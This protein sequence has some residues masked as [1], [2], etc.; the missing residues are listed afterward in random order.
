MRQRPA[1]RYDWKTEDM[2]AITATLSVRSR[3]SPDEMARIMHG[4]TPRAM[5]HK[6]FIYYQDD[7][8]YIHRSW[9]GYCIYI[10]SFQHDS[11]GY[12]IER[13]IANRDPEQHTETNNAADAKK[14]L[15]VIEEMLLGKSNLLQDLAGRMRVE[16]DLAEVYRFIMQPDDRRD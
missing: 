6:W 16:K 10:V 8:L 12:Y 9:T 15:N 7:K 1:T 14:L 3:F 5:E 4:F 11:E 2:P 13:V